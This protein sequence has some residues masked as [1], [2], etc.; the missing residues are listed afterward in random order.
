MELLGNKLHHYVLP[1]TAGIILALYAIQRSGTERVGR[2]F[3]PIMLVWF[4]VLALTG[5]RALVQAPEVLVA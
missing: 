2:L 5:L 3:G 1:I 4:A